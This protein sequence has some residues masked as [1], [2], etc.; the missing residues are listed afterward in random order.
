MYPLLSIARTDLHSS[1]LDYI[2]ILSEARPRG[3][4]CPSAKIGTDIWLCYIWTRH[5][6][7]PLTSFAF[8]MTRSRAASSSR[9]TQRASTRLIERDAQANHI[10]S[11]TVTVVGKHQFRFQSTGSGTFS[12]TRANL[13]NLLAV[14]LNNSP[15]LGRIF[16]GVKLNRIDMRVPTGSSDVSLSSLSVEWTSTLGPSSE[17]SDTGTPL[18]PP[19][20][21][22]TPPR[23]SLS[24]FWSL[25]GSNESDVLMILVIPAAGAIIDVW[26]SFVLQDG[27]TAVLLTPTATPVTGQVYALA[28]DG[29]GAANKL[30]PV[31]YTT[32]I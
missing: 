10:P 7:F 12:I 24:S 17:V 2:G 29:V 27:Q 23:M 13:L 25:T 5:S 21:T 26:V 6:F 30:V 16:S 3:W 4:A 32:I 15:A 28:L 1:S 14:G 11:F 31:S 18:H 8:R 19:Y 9:Q 22:S 20:I